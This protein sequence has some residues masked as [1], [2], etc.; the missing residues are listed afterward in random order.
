MPQRQFYR[1]AT[2]GPGDVVIYTLCQL[3]SCRARPIA[4]LCPAC[5]ARLSYFP[6]S[7]LRYFAAE[8][9]PLIIDR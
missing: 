7:S 4:R 5:A 6:P 9:P 2:L 3:R 8:P 1:P